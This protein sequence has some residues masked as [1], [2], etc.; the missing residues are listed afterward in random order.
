MTTLNNMPDN[1]AELFKDIRTGARDLMIGSEKQDIGRGVVTASVL[2]IASIDVEYRSQIVAR[3][4]ALVS[5]RT[6]EN[7]SEVDAAR[8]YFRDLFLGEQSDYNDRVSQKDEP[9]RLSRDR[10]N[11]KVQV[12][13]SAAMFTAYCVLAVDHGKVW[14]SL[15][16]PKNKANRGSV[17]MT[18][19]GASILWPD[20]RKSLETMEAT[21]V[22][23]SNR[24]GAWRMSALETIGKAVAQHKGIRKA[25][26][27]KAT[28]IRDAAKTL[29]NSLEANDTK[30]LN[31]SVD[32]RLAAFS[33]LIALID[34]LNDRTFT[35]HLD[36]AVVAPFRQ[37]VEARL[38]EAADA[39]AKELPK[40]H[41]A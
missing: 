32:N 16:P 39:K 12:I 5:T 23:I 1:V 7:K 30:V 22:T 6:D 11:N 33:A 37:H 20:R 13:D 3:A 29:Q 27:T 19:D 35:H 40:A 4:T 10:H 9:D 14:Q 18:L 25:A 2:L 41:A 28:P 38:K 21:F 15:S 34:A 24:A 8:V 31:Q 17:N 26:Q 36:S